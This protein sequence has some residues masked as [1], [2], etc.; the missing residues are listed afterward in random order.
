M[1]SICWLTF[2]KASSHKCRR[3]NEMESRS[4]INLTWHPVRIDLFN[5]DQL[6]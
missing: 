1:I 6:F 2:L 3:I 4:F 5:N